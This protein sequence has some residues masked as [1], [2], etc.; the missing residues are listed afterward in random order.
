MS[1]LAYCQITDTRLVHR[2][3]CL[4]TPRLSLVLIAL[5]HEG[6]YFDCKHEMVT[7]SRP[8]VRHQPLPALSSQVEMTEPARRT[9][10]GVSTPC[11]PAPCAV[12]IHFREGWTT[13][14]IITHYRSI[15]LRT[16]GLGANVGPTP[17]RSSPP[18]FFSQSVPIISGVFR[19]WQRGGA[20]AKAKCEPI[21]GNWLR[22]PQ[23]QSKA[24]GTFSF[25]AFSGSDKNCPFF[26]HFEKTQYHTMPLNRLTPSHS[27]SEKIKL[28]EDDKLNYVG[29]IV[30]QK[31]LK[32]FYA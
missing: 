13:C 14:A 15:P 32:I 29:P 25:L 24:L 4:Y 17:T 16:S 22:C 9:G 27:V 23:Q 12:A 3:V 31:A 11:S 1:D 2:A 30:L 18:T 7:Y 5:N 21:K 6:I 10:A 19:I 8:R 20:M 28:F 26:W